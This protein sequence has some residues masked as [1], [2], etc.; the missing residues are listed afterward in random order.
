MGK[1]KI[2]WKE[3]KQGKI[4]DGGGKIDASLENKFYV[5]KFMTYGRYGHWTFGTFENFKL[6]NILELRRMFTRYMA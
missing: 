5:W 2:Y 3:R 4:Y 1:K 6:L